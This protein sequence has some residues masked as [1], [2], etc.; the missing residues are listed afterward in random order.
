MRLGYLG[1][2]GTFTHQ[3]TR[4]WLRGHGTAVGIDGIDA[5]YRAV[6]EGTVDRGVVPIENSV[7]GYVVPSL[8]ALLASEEVLAVGAHSEPI[9]FSAL[10]HSDSAGEPA[11]TVV[12]H[13][14]ALAQCSRFIR[15]RGWTARAASSTGAACRDLRPGEIAIAAAMC[16][17]LYGLSRIADHV[18]DYRGGRTRFLLLARR[19]DAEADIAAA[20]DGPAETI[21]AVTPQRI[22][23]GVLAEVVNV[24]ADS[25][26]NLTSVVTRPLKAQDGKYVF[27]FTIEGHPRQTDL[28][29]GLEDLLAQGNYLKVL[30]V[31]PPPRRPLSEGPLREFPPGSA[32]LSDDSAVLAR[33]LLW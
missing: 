12:S 15:S 8:E 2:E 14:H 19:V 32:R 24:F 11:A 13:P 10:A 17:E 16:A 31:F 20:G 27:V 22:G 3:A 4:H 23:P 21:L 29:R 9:T 5:V 30:G 18:E 26:I 25:R 7:E 28:R 33:A 1:P 6:A